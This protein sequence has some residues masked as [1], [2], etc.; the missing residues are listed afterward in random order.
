MRHLACATVQL[1]TR[2]P[3]GTRTVEVQSRPGHHKQLDPPES[4][5]SSKHTRSHPRWQ[6]LH[7]QAQHA[8][9]VMY[10]R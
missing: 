6:G 1:R 4:T 9:V 2:L 5:C 10:F 7:D 8:Q 3:Y